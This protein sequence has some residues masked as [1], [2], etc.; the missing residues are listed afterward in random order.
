MNNAP[1]AHFE[2]LV[3]HFTTVRVVEDKFHLQ[4]RDQSSKTMVLQI[5]NRRETLKQYMEFKESNKGH[6]LEMLSPGFLRYFTQY[7]KQFPPIGF[8][9]VVLA[10]QK[11]KQVDVFGFG[12]ADKE[13]ELY[14]EARSNQ[15]GVA[16][17]KSNSTDGDTIM[18][19][20]LVESLQKYS[21]GTV[22]MMN[23]CVTIKEQ[24]GYCNNCSAMPL[25]EG[26]R[27]SS[28]K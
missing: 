12:E 13:A 17:E 3:G 25:A 21:G 9:T 16:K 5:V 22:R 27:C 8:I 20:A 19:T 18:E 26:G 10:Y 4:A 24:Y 14:W 1:T 15:F 28:R 2:G 11:C 23:P 7:M 6:N